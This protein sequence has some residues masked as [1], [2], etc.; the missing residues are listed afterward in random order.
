MT[1]IQKYTL[2]LWFYF[3]W[4]GCVYFAKWDLSPWSFVFPAVPWIWFLYFK[5][6]PKKNLAYLVVLSLLGIIFDSWAHYS[7]IISFTE[8][9]SLL[10]PYWLFSMWF[11]FVTVFP[12]SQSF[13]GSKLILAGLLGVVFGPLSYYSGQA[14][15]VFSF[16]DLWSIYIYALFWGIYFPVAL[17]FYRKLL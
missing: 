2:V 7:G 13:L 3:G 14:F 10:L 4:F 12:L 11:L 16:S 5:V 15:G 9:G 1:K 8:S 17:Y 6:F